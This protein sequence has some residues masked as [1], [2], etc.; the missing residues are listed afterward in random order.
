MECKSRHGVGMRF[1]KWD[2]TSM[3]IDTSGYRIMEK[4]DALR[5][6]REIVSWFGKITQEVEPIGSD[7]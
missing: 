1:G 7:W 2:S 5:L 4:V 6:A 3:F